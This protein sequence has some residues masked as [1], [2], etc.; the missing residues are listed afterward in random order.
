LVISKATQSI[1]F[2]AL[3]EIRI[4]ETQIIQLFA[5]ATSGLSVGFQVDGPADISGN[6]I[7]INDISEVSIIASQ[8]EN[9]NYLAA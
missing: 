3:T 7:T 5:S 8:A 6:T 9:E 4:G 2:D 1:V